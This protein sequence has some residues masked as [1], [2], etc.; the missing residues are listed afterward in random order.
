MKLIK[1]DA[2]KIY[3]HDRQFSDNI[4][5]EFILPIGLAK[6][7]RFKETGI[8]K[9]LSLAVEFKLIK[10]SWNKNNIFIQTDPM[11]LELRKHKWRLVWIKYQWKWGNYVSLCEKSIWTRKIEKKF[12]PVV[13]E[14]TATK[15]REKK[16]EARKKIHWINVN[17]IFTNVTR[18]VSALVFAALHFLFLF[19]NFINSETGTDLGLGKQLIRSI[20]FKQWMQST[21][22]SRS[23][24]RMGEKKELWWAWQRKHAKNKK[25]KD[26]MQ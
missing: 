24:K 9:W 10:Y 22:F 3:T 6:Q 16:K 17:G 12:I 19:I 18:K 2:Q 5:F 4:P 15:E 20:H 25:L 1:L 7:R 13:L 14:N 11:E 23:K 21:F 8:M 26:F